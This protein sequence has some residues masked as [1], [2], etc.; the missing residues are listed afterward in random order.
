MRQSK[1]FTKTRKEAPTDEVSRNAE[2]L[3]RGGFIHKEMAG[4]YSYLPMGLRVLKN[5]ENIIREEMNSIGG[6]EMRTSV[7][8]NK[9]VWEKSNRW[10]DDVVDNWFKTELKNGGEIGLSFTNEEAYANIMKQYIH[11]YK[12]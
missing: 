2:F 1:L 5:I 7:F 9:D 4:V 11:S 10:S 8:Q 6:T 12:D 3:I